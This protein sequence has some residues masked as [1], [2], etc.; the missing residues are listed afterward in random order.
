MFKA[1]AFLFAMLAVTVS[2]G[3]MD[4]AAD[5]ELKEQCLWKATNQDC[6]YSYECISNCCIKTGQYAGTCRQRSN[7]QICDEVDSCP[8]TTA[9]DDAASG[10]VL[11]FCCA[12]FFCFIP[13]MVV[14]LVLVLGVVLTAAVALIAV[15]VVVLIALLILCAPCLILCA[16]CIIVCGIPACLCCCCMCVCASKLG[17]GDDSD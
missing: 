8:Q 1:I 12:V 10:L 13:A 16:P 14:L 7:T 6:V 11:L 9:A 4:P 17:G 5:R 15:V 2:A 3:H